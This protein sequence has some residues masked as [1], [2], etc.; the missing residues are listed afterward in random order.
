MDAD[1][2]RSPRFVCGGYARINCLPS[3]GIIL[4]GKVRDLSLGGCCVDGALPIDCGARAEIVVRV[5]A[6]SFR[7]IGLVKAV[8]GNSAAGLEFV[9]LSAGGQEMLADLVTDL[10]KMQALMAQLR[11][12]QRTVEADLFAQQ[13]SAGN[14]EALLLGKRPPAL[15]TILTAQSANLDQTH[16]SEP[17]PGIGDRGAHLVRA[18]PLVITIDLFG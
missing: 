12:A 17:E 15:G 5:N 7:A 10:A 6:S 11:S 14:I 8:R 1:R 13:L 3:T 4:P 9:Q 18:T 2:R 16:S